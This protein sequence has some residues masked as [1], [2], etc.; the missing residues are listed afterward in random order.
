MCRPGRVIAEGRGRTHRSAPTGS[1][2]PFRFVLLPPRRERRVFR[3]EGGGDNWFRIGNIVLFHKGRNTT[4]RLCYVVQFHDNRIIGY[5][6]FPIIS[7]NRFF[8]CNFTAASMH[9]IQLS[10]Q[11]QDIL[12]VLLDFGFAEYDWFGIFLIS[13]DFLNRILSCSSASGVSFVAKHRLKIA[14]TL[15]SFN[16]SGWKPSALMIG[17]LLRK[18][19]TQAPCRAFSG[20]DLMLPLYGTPSQKASHLFLD[21]GLPRVYD[22][23]TPIGI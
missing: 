12:F 18:P 6:L 5:P 1:C 16:S 19:M 3:G 2:L 11:I 21:R 20:A 22:T 13:H 8:R 14:R 15:S 7:E 4:S 9:R 10:H 17:F 23:Y